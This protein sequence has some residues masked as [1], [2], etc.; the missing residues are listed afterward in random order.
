MA[1]KYTIMKTSRYGNMGEAN[2]KHIGTIMRKD[3]KRQ[4]DVIRAVNESA[5]KEKPTQNEVIIYDLYLVKDN[6]DS[7]IIHSIEIEG[8]KS[9]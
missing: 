3:V 1:E 4:D 7:N 2:I 6:G 8:K 5:A 9:L